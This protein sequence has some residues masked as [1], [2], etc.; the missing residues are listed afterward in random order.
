MLKYGVFLFGIS[1][2]VL[3][4]LAFLYYANKENDNFLRCTTKMLKY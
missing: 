4:I 2:S 1:F 3:E